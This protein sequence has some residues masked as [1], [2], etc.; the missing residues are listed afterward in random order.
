MATH[1]LYIVKDILTAS[2]RYKMT[3]F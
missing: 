1:S 3:K 2:D